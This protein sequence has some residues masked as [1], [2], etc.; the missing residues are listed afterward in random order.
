MSIAV[1]IIGI[2]EWE[3]YTFPLIQSIKEH[4]GEHVN[5][6][7]VDNGSE[8][9]YPQTD[10]VR[11][12]K[13]FETMSY[14]AALNLGIFTAGRNDWYIPINNDALFTKPFADTVE[15]LDGN[16]LYGFAT[17]EFG[18]RPYLS[19]WCMIISNWLLSNVGIFDE[20]FAPMWYEDADYC[21]RAVAAGFE[22]EELDRDEFGVMHFA[23]D[24]EKP[25]HRFREKNG[26]ALR[27]NDKYLRWKHDI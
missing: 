17:H 10:G 8:P 7:C 22:L 26:D 27:R 14:P 4:A 19:S 12:V 20:A 2:G 24:R 1:V 23:D 9:Q 11:M 5:I 15:A 13:A 6:V 16:R 25:R 18:E 21:F 3:Q